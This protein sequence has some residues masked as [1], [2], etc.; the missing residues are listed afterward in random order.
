[1]DDIDTFLFGGPDGLP[2]NLYFI[3]HDDPRR[4]T[5]TA[6][7]RD[8]NI[9][10]DNALPREGITAGGDSG[11]PLIIDRA[12]ARP[13]VIGVLSGGSRYFNGQPSSSYGTTSFYQPLYLFWDYIVANNP[14]RYVS[15]VAGDGLWT[16]PA[17]WVTNLDPAYQV[18]GANGQPVNGL[19]T[20]PG[21]GVAGTTP[22]F[23]EL[24]FQ[25]GGTNECQNLATGQ[26]RNNVPNTDGET[27]AAT[28][29]D[30]GVANVTLTDFTAT[31]TLD[32]A[33]GPEAQAMTVA[34]Q[35]LPAATL[36]N[37][38]P[39]AT[40]FVPNNTG[41]VRLTGTPARYYD[42][43]LSAA[44]TT[45]LNSAATIDRLTIAGANSGLTI[46]TAGTLTSLVDITQFAGRTT[47]NGRLTTQGD[48]A[49]MGGLLTG[50]G[51]VQT[52]FLTSVL[53][54]IAPGGLGT[55]G[56]LTVAGN[57][58]LSS[59][60][61]LA[62][63]IGPGGTSDRLAT[64]A[65]GTSSGAINL[66]GTLGLAPVA[67]YRPTFDDRFAFVTAAGGVTGRFG[68]VSGFSGVLFPEL[69]YTASGVTARINARSFTTVIDNGRPVQASYARLL[70]GNRGQYALL[71]GLYGDLDGLNA[72]PLQAALESLAPRTEATKLSMARMGVDTM[73]RF[74][75]DRMAFL[76][77][78][79]A[80]GTL[81]MIGNPVQ[82]AALQTN[83]MGDQP[84]LS[85][86]PTQAAVLPGITLPETV[87][88]FVAGGYVDGSARPLRGTIV[89]GRDRIDGWYVAG[90][91]E[92]QLG[93]RGSVGVGMHYVDLDGAIDA[94]NRQTAGGKLLQGSLYGTYV[95]SAGL[96]FNAQASVG[97]YYT[98]TE[99]SVNTGSVA[100]TLGQKDRNLA[101]SIEGGLGQELA[102]GGITLTPNVALRYNYLDGS[103]AVETGGPAALAIVGRQKGYE[104][105]QGRA[106]V[107]LGGEL[108]SGGTTI[109]PR[110]TGAYVRQFLNQPTLVNA[111]F[112]ATGYGVQAPF[113]LPGDDK[114]WFEVGGGVRIGGKRLSLDLSADTTIARKDIRYRTYRAGVNF[115][116]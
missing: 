89:G 69:I 67:G 116:F 17:R 33:T 26:T 65:N 22:K 25:L 77:S 93:D 23:G 45:T 66:G 68:A 107:D 70:D 102:F 80:G 61:Q 72:A 16:D 110:L 29:R 42:V 88:A 86:Q 7:T 3:D 62:I 103:N 73:G 98:T 82:L 44:G 10:R 95:L 40:N 84:V 49:L 4:G 60:S 85:D 112:A 59:G 46:G 56:T 32:G 106:G 54:T 52:P 91:I 9:F 21:A 92:S 28:L 101:A 108:G 20:S 114:G 63:D 6:S 53:G 109:R 47:V 1:M 104:N 8:F 51:T 55:I 58:I 96:T 90:G 12:F 83:M 115:A 99:R 19:P 94:P 71:S 50:T 15:A 18:L 11:G 31:T 76:R 27:L 38:L 48:Y 100:T 79:E 105:L 24:C 37:G 74:Y 5:A 113:L 35:A 78:G 41:G 2:Q 34:A 87:S 14:Y 81:A 43:T 75:R 36:A 97:S 64:V 13:T 57:A 39:G 111:S 30:G